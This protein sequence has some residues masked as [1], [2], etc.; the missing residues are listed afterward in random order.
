MILLFLSLPTEAFF[1]PC[2]VK[3]KL[4]LKSSVYLGIPEGSA[5]SVDW[6]WRTPKEN[7]RQNIS[8]IYSDNVGRGN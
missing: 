2:H 8:G 1:R 5:V 3:S 4:N 7:Y 6:V